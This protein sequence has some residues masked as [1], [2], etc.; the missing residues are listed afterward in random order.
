MGLWWLYENISGQARDDVELVGSSRS[1]RAKLQP[2][3]TWSIPHGPTKVRRKYTKIRAHT[4]RPIR[5]TPISSTSRW[6]KDELRPCIDM[7][8]F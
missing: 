2:T 1:L 8:I 3:M 5:S 4:P 6:F 7:A